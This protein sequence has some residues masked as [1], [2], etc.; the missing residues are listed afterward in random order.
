[1]RHERASTP[2][3]VTSEPCRCGYLAERADDPSAPIVF[4]RRMNEYNIV[5]QGGSEFISHH[6][7][8]CGG[9]APM[10]KRRNYFATVTEH[11]LQ[12]LRDLTED[13]A[14]LEEAV[15]RFGP[16]DDDRPDGVTITTPGSQST[17]PVTTVHRSLKFSRLSETVDVEIEDH[18]LRGVRAAFAP[19]YIGTPKDD[20]V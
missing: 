3:S 20:E 19:K 8:W 14:S 16:P 2:H 1:M 17:P 4:D 11:E 5:G 9:L 6:C 13:L 18:G 15:A 12:R 10:S 7:P